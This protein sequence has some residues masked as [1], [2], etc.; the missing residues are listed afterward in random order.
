MDDVKL[1]MN[2][3]GFHYFTAAKEFVAGK[4][5]LE[6]K[7]DCEVAAMSGQNPVKSFTRV[8]QIDPRNPYG[9]AYLLFAMEDAGSYSID[10]LLAVADKWHVS[11][12]DFKYQGQ[13]AFAMMY[14]TRYIKLKERINNVSKCTT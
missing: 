14:F 11:A 12:A 7:C 3:R 10:Q 8:T 2:R 4:S 13:S 1:V 6:D 9:W 5:M